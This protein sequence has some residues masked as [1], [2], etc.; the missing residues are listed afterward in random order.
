MITDASA[1]A[2]ATWEKLSATLKA[3]PGGG[4]WSD[5]CMHFPASISY[6]RVSTVKGLCGDASH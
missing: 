3:V 5:I 4:V 2:S 1:I 6:M